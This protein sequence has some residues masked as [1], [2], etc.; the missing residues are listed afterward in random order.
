MASTELKGQSWKYLLPLKQYIHGQWVGSKGA[1]FLTLLSAVDD[2]VVTKGSTS[3]NSWT[4]ICSRSHLWYPCL[5]VGK[6][7]FA[8]SVD[9]IKGDL[10]VSEDGCLRV[11]VDF[12][13][14]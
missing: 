6:L 10:I 2:T 11:G 1:E 9:K 4:M 13:P 5:R 8:G 3:S 14:Q 7:D 12:S